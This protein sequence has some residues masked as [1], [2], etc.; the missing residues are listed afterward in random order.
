MGV[1]AG[2][3]RVEVD[4]G[5]GGEKVRGIEDAGVEAT[6]QKPA[7]SKQATLERL[8][9]LASEMLHEPADAVLR[10]AGDDQVNV[11]RDG[12]VAMDEDLAQVGVVVQKGEEF[13]AV[14]IAEEDLL[15]IIT[16]LG[17]VEGVSGWCESGFAGHLPL[18]GFSGAFFS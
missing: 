11:V 1:D 7:A 3:D 13:G 5:E 14:L 17:Q 8:G 16:A 12:G 10:L 15:A 6:L 2:A 18:S 9:I 4:V